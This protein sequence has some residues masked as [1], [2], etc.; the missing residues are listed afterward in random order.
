MYPNTKY[1]VYQSVVGI[2]HIRI[3]ECCW[4]KKKNEVKTSKTTFS[5]HRMTNAMR[6]VY[7]RFGLVIFIYWIR[8]NKTKSLEHGIAFSK[9]MCIN[10]FTANIKW[11]PF[12]QFNEHHQFNIKFGIMKPIWTIWYKNRQQI[13]HTKHKINKFKC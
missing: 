7:Y 9:V 10:L 8:S 12:S 3:A 11:K 2:L 5:I 6:S 4:S 1:C 13:N